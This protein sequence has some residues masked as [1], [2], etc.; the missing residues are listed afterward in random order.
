MGCYLGKIY[1]E[2]GEKYKYELDRIA[3]KYGLEKSYEDAED[4]STTKVNKNIYMNDK[5]LFFYRVES[6][7]IFG[8]EKKVENFIEEVSLILRENNE[9]FKTFTGFAPP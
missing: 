3:Q 1:I 5:S 2:D 9:N 7:G 4:Y 8:S 6:S